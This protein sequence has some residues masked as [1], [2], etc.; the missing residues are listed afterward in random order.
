MDRLIPCSML[1]L[2]TF[3]CVCTKIVHIFFTVT[4]PTLNFVSKILSFHK[5][6][7]KEKLL[8]QLLYNQYSY[9]L[10]YYKIKKKGV[11]AHLE[12]CDQGFS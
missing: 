10:S 5:H 9:P 6:I 2:K 7:Q 11:F 3:G 12:C 1:I 8:R 4:M